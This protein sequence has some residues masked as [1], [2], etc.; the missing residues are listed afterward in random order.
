MTKRLATMCFVAMSVIGLT[1]PSVRAQDSEFTRATLKDISAVNVLVEELSDGAKTLGL[2]TDAIQTDVEL[3]LRL[4]GIRVVTLEEALKVPG[5]PILYVLV[6]VLPDGRA[7]SIEIELHQNVLLERN[8]LRVVGMPTWNTRYLMWEPNPTA[9][10]V[11]NVVKDQ[12]DVF[13]NAWLAVNP[14]K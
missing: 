14:K 12:V 11:R 8:G 5:G 13:L 10:A 4:A 3:K 6:S 2:T 7:A 1:S 9:Q